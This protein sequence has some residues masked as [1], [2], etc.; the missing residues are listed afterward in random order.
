MASKKAEEINQLKKELIEKDL[1]CSNFESLKNEKYT[2]E[3]TLTTVCDEYAMKEE[4]LTNELD[5][6]RKSVAE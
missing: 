6:V 1:I 3:C 4:E 5:E 2:L